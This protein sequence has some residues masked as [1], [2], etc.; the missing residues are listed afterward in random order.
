M[1]LRWI[2]WWAVNSFWFIIF[3]GLSLIILIRKVDGSGAVQTPEARLISFIVLLV[4]FLIPAF[5]Q[6]I[7]LIINLVTTKKS[8]NLNAQ[9][10]TYVK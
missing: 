7:W 4:A 2:F 8:Q 10:N 1:K 9:N 5:I 3:A 6:I